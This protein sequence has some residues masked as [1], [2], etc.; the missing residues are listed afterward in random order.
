MS[1]EIEGYHWIAC[2]YPEDA[3][4]FHKYEAIFGTL[5]L[6]GVMFLIIQLMISRFPSAT[7]SRDDNVVFLLP[8]VSLIMAWRGWT[9]HEY[10][11]ANFVSRIG[12]SSEGI[13]V[14]YEDEDKSRHKIPWSEISRVRTGPPGRW[15]SHW[16]IIIVKREDLHPMTHIHGEVAIEVAKYFTEWKSKAHLN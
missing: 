7:V 1:S 6:Y 11:K 10:M 8:L 12:L 13:L 16:G 9:L 5:I 4:K 14:E 3:L 2:E 15:N